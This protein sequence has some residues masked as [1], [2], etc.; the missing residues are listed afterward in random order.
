MK[1]RILQEATRLFTERGYRGVALRELAE[2]CGVTQAAFYYHFRN[3]E[4]ILLAILETY[5]E[6]TGADIDAIRSQG[7]SAAAQLRRIVQAL[8]RQRPDQRAVIRLAM[9]ESNHLEPEARRKFA[10]LYFQRFTGQIEALLRQGIAQGEFRSLDSEMYTWMLLGMIFPFVTRGMR[11]NES[12]FD[13]LE[14]AQAIMDTFLWGID[15]SEE[16]EI[17]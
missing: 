2:I 14:T 13:G 8:F 9:Q 4:A 16:E 11:E 3:K 7:G 10:D 15:V 5:L 6:E 1:E 12:G 17:L